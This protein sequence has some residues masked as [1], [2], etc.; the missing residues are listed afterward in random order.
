M[1]FRCLY[2]L[3]ENNIFKTF[4]AK[5]LLSVYEKNFSI[6]SQLYTSKILKFIIQKKLINN[7]L[8][9]KLNKD[10]DKN[11]KCAFIFSCLIQKYSIKP[12]NK[13]KNDFKREKTKKYSGNE[14]KEYS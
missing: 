8:I 7:F 12:G 11:K 6:F 4:T 10:L 1:D 13:S 3:Q 9:I 2:T 14:K 5:I